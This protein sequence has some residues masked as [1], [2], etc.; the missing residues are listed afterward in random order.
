MEIDHVVLGVSSVEETVERLAPVVG[1]PAFRSGHPDLGSE[2][3][4]WVLPEGPYLEVLAGSFIADPGTL[5]LAWSAPD[6]DTVARVAARLR[7]LGAPAPDPVDAWGTAPD[8]RRRT[9]TFCLTPGALGGAADIV[10]HHH[11]WDWRRELAAPT[12][13]ARVGRV[14]V[15]A[16][17][18]G[19]RRAELEEVL[20]RLPPEVEVVRAPADG[21]AAV[22]L[23]LTDGSVVPFR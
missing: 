3:A 2:N 1:E 23:A 8:G 21:V 4:I 20:G 13:A 12:R 18:P 11:G 19:R 9:W 5:H 17:D 22:D 15:A 6:R 10:I 16:V 14:E 7:A